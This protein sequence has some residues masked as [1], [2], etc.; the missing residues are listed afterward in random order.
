MDAGIAFRVPVTRTGLPLADI[1][2]TG[3]SV[4]TTMIALAQAPAALEDVARRR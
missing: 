3:L 1:V 4:V 2:V